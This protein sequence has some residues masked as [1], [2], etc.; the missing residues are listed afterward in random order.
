L[1]AVRE[2]KAAFSAQR[3]FSWP[4]IAW[5]AQASVLTA[6]LVIAEWGVLRSGS[7]FLPFL[8]AVGLFFL[9]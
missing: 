7:E 1:V 2:I 5:L 8:G 9:S 4:S 3:W 6:M